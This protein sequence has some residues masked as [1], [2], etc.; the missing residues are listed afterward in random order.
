MGIKGLM[1]IIQTVAP[2]AIIEKDYSN[3]AGTT[4]ALDMLLIIYKFVIAIRGRGDDLHRED[5]QMTSH[6]HG[7][8]CKL[9][10]MIKYG[11]IPIPIFDGKS[12]DIKDETLRE[13]KDKKIEASKKLCLLD[14]KITK[15]EKIKLYKRSFNITNDHITDVKRLVNLMGF[16]CVQAPGEADSQ[17]AALNI[18]GVVDAVVTEDMDVLVFGAKKMLRKFSNKNKVIQIDHDRILKDMDLTES[19]FIDICILLG[20][21]YSKPIK[22]IGP[23]AVYKKYKQSGNME[24]FLLE[25]TR[26]NNECIRM[27]K[28]PKYD[29]PRNFIDRWKKTKEYFL[30]ADVIDPDEFIKTECNK[31][32]N[33]YWKIPDANGLYNFLCNE[34]GFNKTTVNEMINYITNRYNYYEE[35]GTL[36]VDWREI[37]TKKKNINTIR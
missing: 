14:D 16:I 19:Q 15:S 1:K 20:S 5:G 33:C 37:K 25:L 11:I 3:F 24:T 18:K 2:D 21:D 36:N 12:P 8:L 31:N 7:S 4:V 6:I 32:I 34:N 35:H 26:L 10:N 9:V 23:M 30:C 13:R 28:N 22:G 29:I 27:G 17:C